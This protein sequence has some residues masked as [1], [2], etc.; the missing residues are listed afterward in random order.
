MSCA[1]APRGL[2]RSALLFVTL[3]L[4]AAACADDDDGALHGSVHGTV[5][6]AMSQKV[7]KG[8]KVAFVADTLEQAE[9]KTDDKG[10]F[11]ISVSAVTPSGRLTAEKAGYETRTVSVFLDDGDVAV[12][13]ELEQNVEARSSAREQD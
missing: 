7:L 5:R 9:D 12:D 8:V 2:A 13:I 11:A 10:R 4:G 3:T 6:D 1:R